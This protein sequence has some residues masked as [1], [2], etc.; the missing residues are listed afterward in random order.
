MVCVAHLRRA[1]IVR[2]IVVFVRGRVET[3]AAIQMKAALLAVEIVVRVRAAGMEVVMAT[4]L[5]RL[6]RSTADHVLPPVEM[7]SAKPPKHANLVRLIAGCVPEY[8]A[9]A[10]V[11][12]MNP[13]IVVHWTAVNARLPAVTGSVGRA[14]HVHLVL[15]IVEHVPIV[16]AMELVVSLRIAIAVLPIAEFV[17]HVVETVYAKL[18]KPV[19]L[20]LGIAACARGAAMVPVTRARVVRA[21]L[22][23]V[24]FVLHPVVMGFALGMRPATIVRK[25]AAPACRLVEM[26][27]VNLWRLVRLVVMTA[28]LAH[29][30][31]ET[32]SARSEKPVKAAHTI[33]VT[34][35]LYAATE[36]A[37]G[38]RAAPPV[39]KIAATVPISVGMV[40]V[41]QLKHALPARV[42]VVYAQDVAM[43][44]A[45]LRKHVLHVAK[46]AVIA[47]I[48]AV[49]ASVGRA[50]I[51]P[52]V[53]MI[54]DSVMNAATASVGLPNHV[55]HVRRIVEPVRMNAAMGSAVPPSRVGVVRKIVGSVRTTVVMESV[56]RVKIAEPAR[57][58]VG[59]AR[60]AAMANV[61]Q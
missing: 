17:L 61:T 20:V 49:M 45:I 56:G 29:Q 36:T 6:A 9:T 30:H 13:V 31:V 55:L 27:C 14:R 33:A 2:K 26:E 39:R 18:V 19:N 25:I 11:I 57:G 38:R 15:W 4:R 48:H 22:G 24:E 58:I 12:W 5:A 1:V 53:G 16:V 52:V 3:A 42:I 50:R 10:N 40:F 51:A 54:V 35:I 23:I 43:G 7:E 21:A 41:Q 60:V 37:S 59:G 46:T 34:V 47:R 28:A 32:G 44:N 8:A